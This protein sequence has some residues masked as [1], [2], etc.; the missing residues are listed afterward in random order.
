MREETAQSRG[1]CLCWR[2]PGKVKTTS[3]SC[4]SVCGDCLTFLSISLL[5]P[6]AQRLNVEAELLRMEALFLPC[7]LLLRINA[8]L[9]METAAFAHLKKSLKNNSRVTS[10]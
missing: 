5:T 1:P 4:V 7:I 10:S 2:T 6:N 8:G 3:R 9:K